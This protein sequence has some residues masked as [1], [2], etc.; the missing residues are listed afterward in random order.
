MTDLRYVPG[1]SHDGGVTKHALADNECTIFCSGG[2]ARFKWYL[3]ICY[4]QKTDGELAECAV[5]VFP[6]ADAPEGKP[7]WGLK[8]VKDGCWQVSPSIKITTSRPDPSDPSR[9]QEVELWH[10]TPVVVGVP[11]EE[12]WTH[13]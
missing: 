6:N 5:P 12:R 7:G 11:E 3:R 9:Q 4:R 13:G 1:A 2:D 10:E 8:R